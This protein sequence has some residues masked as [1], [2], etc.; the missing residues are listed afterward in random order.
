M[1]QSLALK[2]EYLHSSSIWNHAT[3]AS[4]LLNPIEIYLTPRAYSG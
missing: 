4:Y 3:T 1:E 2:K